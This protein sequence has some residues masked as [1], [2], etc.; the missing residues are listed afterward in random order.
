MRN[1]PK[2]DSST[3]LNPQEVW[4][5]ILVT[6]WRIDQILQQGEH[7]RDLQAAQVALHELQLKTANYHTLVEEMQAPVKAALGAHFL[8][9]AEWKQGFGVNVGAP[10]PI[11]EY[12]TYEL[13]NS[14]C[15]LHPGNM[16]KDTH[17]FILIPK[18]VDNE[19][20]TPLKLALLCNKHK[21]SGSSLICD[22]YNFDTWWKDER[23]ASQ[24]LTESEWVLIPKSDPVPTKVSEERHFRRKD[25][26]EQLKVYEYYAADYRQGKALEVMSAAILDE[27]VNR[28][29][30][31][32]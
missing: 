2:H 6:R 28:A 5:D 3:A 25:W 22:K 18:N 20:Y 21:G 15:P 11:P 4:D 23:W 32:P 26:K 14:D 1:A 27:V 30:R 31:E 13:L 10:P 24:S 29:S 16:I 19:P 7:T 12:I 8:G 9:T 17:I